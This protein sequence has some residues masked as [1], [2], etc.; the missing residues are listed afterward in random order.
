M[1]DRPRRPLQKNLF[2]GK[3]KFRINETLLR[4]PSYSFIYHRC[5]SCSATLPSPSS[6]PTPP[7]YRH[8][9]GDTPACSQPRILGRSATRTSGDARRETTV[10]R[11][12]NRTRRRRPV[13]PPTKQKT[14]V[15]RSR[16][17]GHRSV[18]SAPVVSVVKMLKRT[19][20]FLTRQL[21]EP[22]STR[23]LLTV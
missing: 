23:P 11:L 20:Q 5:Y 12:D 13:H 9:T 15:F 4:K 17:A 2:N 6:I 1:C 14:G 10:T 8:V 22:V 19:L 18:R 7:A 16:R 3:Q 21:Y